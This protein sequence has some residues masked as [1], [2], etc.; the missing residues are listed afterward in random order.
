MRNLGFAVIL[1]LCLVGAASARFTR[2]FGSP[3]RPKDNAADCLPSVRKAL[4]NV[5]RERWGSIRFDCANGY[6][7]SLYFPS[8]SRGAMDIGGFTKANWHLFDSEPVELIDAGTPFLTVVRRRRG[9]RFHT[10]ELDSGERPA[11][12]GSAMA[13]FDLG[14]DDSLPVGFST[15]T[16]TSQVE[17]SAKSLTIAAKRGHLP[18]Q[19]QDEELIIANHCLEDFKPKLVWFVRIRETGNPKN[20]DCSIDA[21]TGEAC[22]WNG[23]CSSSSDLFEQ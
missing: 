17:A 19:T 4:A 1:I 23:G 7:R 2:M 22:R 21:H 20:V 18:N 5:D 3:L 10:S 15:S 12:D 6:V 14:K 8:Q 11:S 16:F 9:L 13:F